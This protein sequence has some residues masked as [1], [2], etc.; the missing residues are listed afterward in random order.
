ML[1]LASQS[2]RR[3]ELPTQ[4]G[5]AFKTA[6]VD[7]DE[8][9]LANE[10]PTAYVKRLSIAKAQACYQQH[11]DHPALG[12][13]TAVIIDKQILGKPRDKADAIKMLLQLSGREHHVLTG[14]A[15]VDQHV[16]YLQNDTR[17]RFRQINEAEAINYWHT[18]EPA[19][20]AGAYGIQGLG[21]V[22]IEQIAGSYSGVMGL[23]LF[24]TAQLLQQ[25]ELAFGTF[26]LT[27][28]LGLRTDIS[29]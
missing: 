8:T 10:A 28:S 24:E 21:A 20:K 23:P 26:C 12:S 1:Y 25:A 29:A 22:F 3:A 19:D 27:N 5:V 2:P 13:D 7:I 4:I 14:V 9:P 11:P 16:R 18:G 17:V 6:P 15:L